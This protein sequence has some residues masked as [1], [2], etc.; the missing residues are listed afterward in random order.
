M[1]PDKYTMAGGASA[2]SP[3]LQWVNAPPT[4]LTFVMIMHDT[5]VAAQRK[6]DDNLHWMLFN[7]PASTSSL[8]EGVVANA[9]LPDGTVQA[10]HARGQVGY[11]P[12]GAPA[13]PYH[14]YIFELYGLDTKLELGPDA[15]RA[16]IL[17]AMDGHVIAKHSIT[18][19]FHR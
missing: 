17:K 11:M 7:I 5:D 4:V 14:H 12:P 19:R 18:G 16:D 15:T 3:A 10:K 9:S 13:G 1:I 6:S 8:P 2:G